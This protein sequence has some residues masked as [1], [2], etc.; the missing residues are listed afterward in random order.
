MKN[1]YALPRIDGMFDQL[2][3]VAASSNID[4]RL[5][6]HR[7]RIREE[8]ISKMTFTALYALYECTDMSFGREYVF[9]YFVRK[10][11]P[12]LF[13]SLNPPAPFSPQIADLTRAIPGFAYAASRCWQPIPDHCTLLLPTPTVPPCLSL[14]CPAPRRP[15]CSLHCYTASQDNRCRTRAPTMHLAEP[16]EVIVSRTA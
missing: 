9:R 1:K 10:R 4:L 2:K 3:G 12:K 13:Q 15:Y 8:D 5:G 7:L 6:Y 14:C 16:R 11:I